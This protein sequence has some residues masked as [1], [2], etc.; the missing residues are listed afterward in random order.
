MIDAPT[1]G[2]R[3]DKSTF[4]RPEGYP[5]VLEP[6]WPAAAG[7]GWSTKVPV[8]ASPRF[9]ERLAAGPQFG[10]C[11][12]C[13]AGRFW[14]TV[15]P[16]GRVI[17]CHLTMSDPEFVA[18][19]GLELGFAEAFRR[20]PRHKRGPG[21]AVSPYQE[22]DLIFA[23]DPAAIKAALRRLLRPRPL[24]SAPDLVRLARSQ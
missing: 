21:C 22:T 11:R 18:P 5:F 12:N 10:D 9:I 4:P 16:E 23:L 20:L 19:S 7:S 15:L 1:H 3:L 14:G 17:P 2:G 8:G 24:D 13:T 6:G